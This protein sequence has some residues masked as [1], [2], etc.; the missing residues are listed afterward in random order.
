MI[1]AVTIQR[2]D[3]LDQFR[4]AARK[5]LAAGAAPADVAWI[6]ETDGSLFREPLPPDEKVTAVPR[7]FVAL[8]DAVACHRDEQRWPL[9]YEVLW[10]ID[11]GERD[12]LENAAD[13]TVHRLHRMAAAVRRD[14][15]QMTAFVRFRMVPG[16]HGDMYVAWHEPRHHILRRT[17]SFFID[18]F[19][20]MRFSILTPELSLHWDGNV[21]RF[22]QGLRREDAPSDDNVE[23]WWRRY[24]AAVFN[25][26]RANPRL[27]QRHMPRRFWNNLPEATIIQDLTAE[28]GARTDLMTRSPAENGA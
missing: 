11:R 3:D 9:L 28:A 21:E 12:P 14:Q 7:A 1:Y 13:L 22:G 17:S 6:S 27:M 2:P 26:A 18:R 5:L 8:A 19:A 20:N 25:P 24:Y 16:V 23:D 15:H 10:R 4:N